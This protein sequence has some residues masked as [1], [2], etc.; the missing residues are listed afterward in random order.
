MENRAKQVAALE[1]VKWIKNGMIIGV[2]TGTTVYY[3]IQELIQQCQKGLQISA[4]PTS[5]KTH[6]LLEGKIPIGDINKIEQIDIT[7]DGADEINEKKEMIKGG[8][9]AL[10]RE[11]MVASL[12]KEMIVIVDYTKQVKQLGQFPLPVEIVPFAYMCTIKRLKNL[13][14]NPII[15]RNPDGEIFITDNEHFI[16]DIHFQKIPQN[17]GNDHEKI[18]NVIGVV[19]TGYFSNL[20]G[21]VITGFPDGTVKIEV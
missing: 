11:K 7:V 1:A 9:G 4:I 18:R 8:G 14:Y 6:N 21:P 15:R 10:F 5:V 19:E 17:L 20:A 2:G 16:L 13:G 3:F 12:S